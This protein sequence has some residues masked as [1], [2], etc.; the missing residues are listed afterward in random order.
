MHGVTKLVTLDASY[1]GSGPGPGGEVRAG[2][3]AT[4]RLNRKD[5]E[6]LWNRAPIRAARCW[7][8]R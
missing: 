4:T 1:L 7:G 6:I 2:F 8:R 5:F 3:E